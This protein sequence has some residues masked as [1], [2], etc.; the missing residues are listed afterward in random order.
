MTSALTNIDLLADDVEPG[1][2]AHSTMHDYLHVGL[3]AVNVA[4]ATIL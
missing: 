3:K 4:S 1:D 2:L